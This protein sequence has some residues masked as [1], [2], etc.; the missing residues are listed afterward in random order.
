MQASEDAAPLLRVPPE[1]I[2]QQQTQETQ[3]AMPEPMYHLKSQ[4]KKQ[5]NKYKQQCG[6]LAAWD[7]DVNNAV[8]YITH[9]LKNHQMTKPTTTVYLTY[10]L[11]VASQ[12]NT[13][14]YTPAQKE[15]NGSKKQQMR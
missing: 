4:P 7:D 10:T 3:P 13:M 8:H 11:A 2:Q 9:L 5:T 14:T 1:T 12:P 15:K 6:K